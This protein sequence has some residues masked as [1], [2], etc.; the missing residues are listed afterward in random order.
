MDY[1]LWHYRKTRKI[2]LDLF[3]LNA[4]SPNLSSMTDKGTKAFVQ[5][6]Y[7][8]YNH[9]TTF[10][11]PESLY[12]QLKDLSPEEFQIVMAL[13]ASA[14]N[15]L[16]NSFNTLQYQDMIKKEIDRHVQEFEVQK[17]AIKG[18]LDIFVKVNE[19]EKLQLE[20]SHKESMAALDSEIQQLQSKLQAADF[21]IAKMKD[22]FEFL[23]NEKDSNTRSTIEEIVR[24]KEA[25]YEKELDRLQS[26][27]KSMLESLELQARERVAQ[28]DSQHKESL[29]KM[30]QMYAE[31][32]LKIR[33][34]LEKSF[35]SSEKGKQGEK[36]FDEL[37]EQYTIWPKLTNMSKTSHG[38]DRACKIRN[39]ETLFEIKNYSSDVPT[40]EVVKFERDMEEHQN[41]PLGVFISMK[42][43]IVGKKSGNFISTSW[44]SKNQLLIYINSFYT[45]SPEDILGFIDICADIA[46]MFFK[47]AHEQPQDS[48][49]T[50]QL[51]G[52]ISQ[53]KIFVEKELKR[54]SEFLQ[55][56]KHDKT[57]LID[58]ITKQNATYMYQIQQSKQALQGMLDI[59]LGPVEEP[60]A[61][62]TNTAEP[63]AESAVSPELPKKK[64]RSKT[65]KPTV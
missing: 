5:E 43:N 38:T 62:E 50:L 48:D 22:S 23:K 57:F 2:H 40:S 42:T 35:V 53:V 18:E 51:Q 60:T 31:Q 45:H 13:A 32:E 17:N 44:T 27:H 55:T 30:R 24:Q 54:M 9:Y 10:R 14:V 1:I 47:A 3:P 56:L 41:C 63:L 20:L 11:H 28:C 37:T 36:E 34:E 58:S 6:E 19:K 59:F 61:E 46:W 33:R 39:C 21:S 15:K 7:D 65:T 52:K 26:M 29:E 49:T 64:G 4:F 16:N 8:N 12:P 25:Q